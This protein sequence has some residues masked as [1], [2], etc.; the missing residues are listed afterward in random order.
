M[1]KKITEGGTYNAENVQKHLA[2][3]SYSLWKTVYNDRIWISLSTEHHLSYAKW[4]PEKFSFNRW[5]I[6]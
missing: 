5:D 2:S 1:L 3:N 4:S 6:L